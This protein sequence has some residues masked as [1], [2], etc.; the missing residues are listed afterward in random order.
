[1]AGAL[2]ALGFLAHGGSI[3]GI[4]GLFVIVVCLKKRIE[5]KELCA[6]LVAALTLYLPWVLYQ[7][8]YDPPGDRLLKW[9][10]AGVTQLDSRSFSRTFFDA[11][12]EA[13]FGQ[14]LSYK[15]TNLKTFADHELDYWKNLSLLSWQFMKQGFRSSNLLREQAADLRRILFFYMGPNLGPLIFGPLLLLIKTKKD[16]SS[17]E[18]S[19]SVVFFCYVAFTLLIWCL[20]MFTPGSTVIHT[21][22][23]AVVLVAYSGSIL[24]FW[25]FSPRI[26]A[27]ITAIQIAI[28]TLLYLVLLNW[29][30]W[31]G[32]VRYATVIL[33]WIFLI[34]TRSLLKNLEGA[35]VTRLSHFCQIRADEPN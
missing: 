27:T 33:G 14:V 18:R 26:A 7:R 1:L 16:L 22:T 13:G 15:L 20:L 4:V 17:P 6:F 12:R 24:A 31:S 11:Y 28:N 29:V 35:H 21:G 19:A 10:L 32:S 9:H 30:P 8:L 3:F 2:A 34:I 5:Y 25:Q 23:Y